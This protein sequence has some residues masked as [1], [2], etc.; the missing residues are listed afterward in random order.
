LVNEKKTELERLDVQH[1][2]LVRVEAE[3][4]ALIDKLTNNEA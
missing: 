2:S 3:Q 4:K 1:D